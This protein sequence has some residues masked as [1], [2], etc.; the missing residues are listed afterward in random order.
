MYAQDAVC[1]SRIFLGPADLLETGNCTILNTP[2]DFLPMASYNPA[3]YMG[4]KELQAPGALYFSQQMPQAALLPVL[5]HAGQPPV[6]TSTCYA[7][8]TTSSNDDT[9]TKKRR[10]MKRS[11]DGR[12]KD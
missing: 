10:V 5:N 4:G 6:V 12:K 8:T 11:V 1:N 2:W 7:T 9:P 3:L